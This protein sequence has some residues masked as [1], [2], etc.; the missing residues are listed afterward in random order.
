MVYRSKINIFNL[1]LISISFTEPAV[2]FIAIGQF[3]YGFFTLAQFGVG[4][5]FGLGQFM[6]GAFSIAQFSFGPIMSIGQFALGWFSIGM[7]AAGFEG[8]H[9][10]GYHFIKRNFLSAM[11]GDWEVLGYN[12]LSMI[13]FI[14]LVLIFNFLF[15][16]AADGIAGGLKTIIN[17]MRNKKENEVENRSIFNTNTIARTIFILLSF[18]L[19]W[20]FMNYTG[21][22][23]AL[24]K[25]NYKYIEKNGRTAEAEILKIKY[26]GV[27]INDNNVA[28]ITVKIYPDD[29]ETEPFTAKIS[30]II[31]ETDYLKIEQKIQ[32]KYDPRI[33]KKVIWIKE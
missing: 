9:M 8:L 26:P 10:M 5:I 20:Q 17:T 15:G 4:L 6:A 13:I 28:V 12:M 24:D 1:P 31:G 14:S 33:P 25:G 7:I 32:V 22:S 18:V 3:G 29:R 30:T 21:I 23:S 2:G 16:F 19:I 27:T 11:I